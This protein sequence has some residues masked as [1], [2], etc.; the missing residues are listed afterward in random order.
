M[1]S[2]LHF[3]HFCNKVQKDIAAR[4]LYMMGMRVKLDCTF[5]QPVNEDIRGRLA[6]WGLFAPEARQVD[7]LTANRMLARVLATSKV[8]LRTEPRLYSLQK[9]REIQEREVEIQS[10]QLL[11]QL[12]RFTACSFG[13]Y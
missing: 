5:L 3:G 4:F 12:V 11:G 7:L 8:V 13:K 10:I 1:A 9:M 2:P 6:R